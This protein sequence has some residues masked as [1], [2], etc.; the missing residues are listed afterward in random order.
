[1]SAVRLPLN[2]KRKGTI[3]V[4]YVSFSLCVS[5]HPFCRLY[6]ASAGWKWKQ[7]KENNRYFIVFIFSACFANGVLMNKK[8]THV[9]CTD[10]RRRRRRQ[11]W[12]LSFDYW[13]ELLESM[14]KSRSQTFYGGHEDEINCLV[15]SKDLEILLTA[16]I[17]GYIR[18]WNTVYEHL[19]FKIAEKAGKRCTSKRSW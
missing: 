12:N 15:F 7:P 13:Q 4:L 2:L 19:T 3:F 17:D 1:M 18:L 11:T 16:S 9:S 14:F 10:E 6:E 5:L 8:Q